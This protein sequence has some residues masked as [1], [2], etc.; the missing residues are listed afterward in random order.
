MFFGMF[1][2]PGPL[3]YVC[4]LAAAISPGGQAFMKH[5]MTAPPTFATIETVESFALQKTGAKNSLSAPPVRQLLAEHCFPA[6]ANPPK[7]T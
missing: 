1:D 7:K 3:F 5:S 6:W 2:L 4:F